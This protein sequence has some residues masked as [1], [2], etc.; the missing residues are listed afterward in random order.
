MPPI[1]P[2]PI[3]IPPLEDGWRDGKVG[4]WI[5]CACIDAKLE[6]LGLVICDGWRVWKLVLGA[7]WIGG[8]VGLWTFGAWGWRERL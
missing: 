5:F 2:P 8:K 4:L 3:P 1:P 6:P 7:G